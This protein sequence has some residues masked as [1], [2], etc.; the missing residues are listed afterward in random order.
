[1]RMLEIVD[2][3][4]QE[5]ARTD[6]S[7]GMKSIMPDEYLKEG[8][9]EAIQGSVDTTT[10]VM[11]WCIA[12]LA[13]DPEYQKRIHAEMD[14]ICGPDG[15]QLEHREK[16]VLLNH[17]IMESLRMAQISSLVIPHKATDTIDLGGGYPKIPKGATLLWSFTELH[18]D[19]KLWKDPWVF[20]PDRFAV[21]FPGLTTN[22]NQGL[23]STGE[24]KK[25]MP[26]GIGPRHCPG[27]HLATYELY[28][29]LSKLLWEYEYRSVE[30]I[31]LGH[32]TNSIPVRVRNFVPTIT[33][34][35]KGCA[36]ST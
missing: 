10:A 29:G 18:G 4:V 24:F 30:K 15:P 32:Y 7:K 16:L 19:E 27:Y 36:A 26:F 9:F 3:A 13:N 28:V 12:Y 14:T 25:F 2:F 33:R 34:R 8:F 1:M 21:D 31:D 11:E 20:R 6:R 35:A 22:P 17:A 23:T 5:R